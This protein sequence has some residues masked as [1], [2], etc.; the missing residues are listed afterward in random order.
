MGTIIIIKS[1]DNEYL[2][3]TFSITYVTSGNTSL[4]E[5]IGTEVPPKSKSKTKLPPQPKGSAHLTVYHQN[6]QGFKGK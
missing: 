6:I 4:S 5:K 2:Y 1:D 3:K